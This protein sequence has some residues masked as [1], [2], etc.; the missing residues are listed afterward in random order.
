MPSSQ[1]GAPEPACPAPRPSGP[2]CGH[3]G[4]AQRL[5]AA[6]GR[7]GALG[8]SAPATPAEAALRTG[9]EAPGQGGRPR[10][11]CAAPAPRSAWE[12]EL[13]PRGKP[14]AEGKRG[15]ADTPL[16][17]ET[18]YVP[19]R[20]GPWGTLGKAAS[21]PM[22]SRAAGTPVAAG[23]AWTAA[24]SLSGDP[25]EPT[26]GGRGPACSPAGAGP[27]CGRG[28]LPGQ[29]WSEETSSPGGRLSLRHAG[30][31]RTV[32]APCVMTPWSAHCAP[33]AGVA[34]LAPGTRAEEAPPWERPRAHR[35][36]A[37]PL[38]NTRLRGG[39]REVR[40]HP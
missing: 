10:H 9:S 6:D 30:G 35:C 21:G 15:A 38:T 1:R 33:G 22:S 4:P 11:A 19:L 26:R 17:V 37:E 31:A 29:A 18:G 23:T 39:P 20:G 25:W 28:W 14:S 36:A 3:A 12:R 5:G 13:C 32:P 40:C 24:P 16:A 7:A 8:A 27:L 2:P 34:A